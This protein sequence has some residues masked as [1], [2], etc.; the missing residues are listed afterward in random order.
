MRDR[1]RELLG[2]VTKCMRLLEAFSPDRPELSIEQFSSLLGIPK[3][4]VYRMLHTLEARRFVE[5]NP[6]TGA[7]HLGLKLWEIGCV[8]LG[9]VGLRQAA[10]PILGKLVNLCK[11]TA[12]LAVL[13]GSEVVYMDVVDG[14]QPLRFHGWLGQRVPAHATGTGK[15]LLA[16]LP[17]AALEEI[18]AKG[19]PRFTSR[20]ITDRDALLEELAT[21][22]QQGYA[23]RGGDWIEDIFGATAPVRDHTGQVIAALGVAGPTTRFTDQYIQS[24]VPLV[25]QAAGELSRALGYSST[26]NQSAA[27]AGQPV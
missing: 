26:S 8:A 4:T 13:D 11:E 18:T 20:T 14:P 24:L 21:I 25:L 17:P 19:L 1:P 6:E 15:V 27:D 10:S 16:H 5:R 2:S 23:F 22:R 7:Y 12:L 9:R 3:S